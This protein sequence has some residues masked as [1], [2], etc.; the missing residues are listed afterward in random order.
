MRLGGT[1]GHRTS[2]GLYFFW[3]KI[4]F[5]AD[6]FHSSAGNKIFVH[7]TIASAV[8]RVDFVSDRMSYTVL[9]RCWCNIIDRNMNTPSQEKSDDLKDGFYEEIEQDFGHFRKYDM[10]ILLGDLKAKVGRENIF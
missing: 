5:P 3:I 9:S 1:K 8:K 2:R 4:L 6:D 10:K 7:R